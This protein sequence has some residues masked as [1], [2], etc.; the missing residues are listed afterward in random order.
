MDQRVAT[1]LFEAYEK[2]LQALTEAES[3]LWELP[4]GEVR[5]SFTRAHANVVVNILSKLRAPLVLTFPDLDRNTPDGPAEN[6]I[7]PADQEA[8][9]KLTP[10]QIADIDR[11][12]LSDCA[13]SWRKVA[14]IVGSAMSEV[15]NKPPGLPD[16]F[17]AQRVGILVQRGLL[18]SQGNLAYMRYSE[19]R[20]P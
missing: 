6:V 15:G 9:D 17:Y 3:E 10:D 7:D 19:V 4:A 2:A 16:S 12:L 1:K 8:V 5:D 14:R 11:A 18:E 13:H 20:L